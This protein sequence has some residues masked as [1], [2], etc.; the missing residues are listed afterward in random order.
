MVV[1]VV[2]VDFSSRA[3]VLGECLRIHSPPA[4]FFKVEISLRKLIPLLRPGAVMTVA[5]CSMKI[6]L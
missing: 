3:R 2:V 6:C 5:E 4:L 1:V